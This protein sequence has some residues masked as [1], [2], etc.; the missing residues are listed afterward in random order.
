MDAVMKRRR[1]LSQSRHALI[2]SAIN[3][4]FAAMLA[5]DFKLSIIAGIFATNVFIFLVYSLDLIVCLVLLLNCVYNLCLWL[6]RKYFMTDMEL[7]SNQMKAFGVKDNEIGFKEC[8]P[9]AGQPSVE[10]F[11]VGSPTLPIFEMSTASDFDKHLSLNSTQLSEGLNWTLD[12][13]MDT[14]SHSWQFQSHLSPNASQDMSNGSKGGFVRHRRTTNKANTSESFVTNERELDHY[15]KDFEQREQR[16]EELSEL[17]KRRQN[18]SSTSGWTQTLAPAVDE[19]NEY[20]Y[21]FAIES[22]LRL[23]NSEFDSINSSPSSSKA[24]DSLLTKLK[25]DEIVMNQWIENIRKWISLTILCRV[26][27]QMDKINDLLVKSGHLDT[28]IGET[29]VQTLKQIIALK[30]PQLSSLESFLP[31]L[32]LTS[33][34]QYLVQRIRELSKGG[35]IN[36]FQWNSGGTYNLKPWTDELVTDSAIIMH[37]FC[38][39]MD[40]RLPSNPNSPD[41]KAFTN[42]YYKTLSGPVPKSPIYILEAKANA[43][44]FKVYTKEDDVWELPIGRNNLFHSL[45]VF[46]HCIKNEQLGYL[47]RINLGSSGINI[48]WFNFSKDTSYLL[49]GGE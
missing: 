5:I 25:I 9:I 29:S 41:G 19:S 32:E 37:L 18:N 34:Q 46:L 45:L 38:T 36:K 7:T 11:R 1:L 21:Q 26:V 8:K 28:V 35:S 44:H 42:L 24:M 6:W 13:S 31:F 10:P 43:P 39:Y 4:F 20:A 23:N 17:D 30:K 47:G 14:T 27:E 15:L 3:A 12:S 48:L 22:P 40:L 2:W 49:L 33:N 16:M